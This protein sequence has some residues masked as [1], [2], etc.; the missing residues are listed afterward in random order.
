MWS[1][2]R[3]WDGTRQD[4]PLR[5]SA[6]FPSNFNLIL[7]HKLSLLPAFLSL[8]EPCPKPLAAEC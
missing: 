3:H 2:V 1:K 4:L 5:A 7:L 8:D 6:F